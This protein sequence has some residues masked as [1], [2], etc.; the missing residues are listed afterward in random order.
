[1]PDIT[2]MSMS[3]IVGDVVQILLKEIGELSSLG[4]NDTSLFLKV[5]GV[6]ETGLWVHHPNYSVVQIND[7]EGK[8]LPEDKQ[9]HKE[10]DANFLIRWEQ[11]TTI[12]HFPNLEGFDF[13]NPYEK[14]IGFVMPTEGDMPGKDSPDK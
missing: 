7:P 9:I 1:M 11:I 8:P 12:V 4:F 13:P 6:D 2:T 10:V 3:D 14:H 5:M